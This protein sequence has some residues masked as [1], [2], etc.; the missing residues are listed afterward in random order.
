MHTNHIIISHT[1]LLILSPMDSR[2][3]PW[4]QFS[5]LRFYFPGRL[6]YISG[7]QNVQHHHTQGITAARPL[8]IEGK[9]PY[10]YSSGLDRDGLRVTDMCM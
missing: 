6:K 10:C 9:Q 7:G 1:L 2:S 5:S 3:K 4:H 8:C